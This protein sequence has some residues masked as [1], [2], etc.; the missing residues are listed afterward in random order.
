[1]LLKQIVERISSVEFREDKLNIYKDKLIRDL[2]NRKTHDPYVCFPHP[3]T[4]TFPPYQKQDTGCGKTC[5][6]CSHFD[7]FATPSSGVDI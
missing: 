3:H 1:L 6:S 5:V 2:E 7:Y 4:H